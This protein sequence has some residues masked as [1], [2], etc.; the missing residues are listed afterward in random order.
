[1]FFIDFKDEGNLTALR[2]S[3]GNLFLHRKPPSGGNLFLR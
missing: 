1:M 2:L 3:G